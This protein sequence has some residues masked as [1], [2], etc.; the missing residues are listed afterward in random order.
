MIGGKRSIRRHHMERMIAKA[1]YI[2]KHW[3]HGDKLVKDDD[4]VNRM[5]STHCR[6]CSCWMCIQHKDVPP[7]RERV[8]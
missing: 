2:I 8:D 6:P 4:F 3:F 7:R 5:V 1:K